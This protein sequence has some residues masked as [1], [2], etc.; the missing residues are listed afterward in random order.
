MYHPH[1]HC[2]VPGGGVSPHEE[3]RPAR[4]NFLV[5]VK[6]LSPIFRAM[7]RDAVAKELPDLKVPPGVWTKPW[8]VYSKPAPARGPK[9]LA[10][11]QAVLAYLG[12]YVH[13]VAITNRNILSI[14][15]GQVT[16]RY[17]ECGES[18][19]RTQTVAAGEF[20]RRF[21]QHTLPAGCHK[22]R[23]YGLWSA[24]KRPLLRRVQ[25]LLALDPSADPPCPCYSPWGRSCSAAKH[26]LPPL[27]DPPT[28]RPTLEGCRCPSCGQGILHR[29][30]RL[31]RHGR[32]P[33]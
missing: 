1:V 6:A 26:E 13:R 32:A 29:T 10:G 7:V 15:D 28:P 19:W 25:V 9:G 3:W 12:R 30:R 18:I 2:L 11:P 33:P 31:K 23:Y 17:Q 20:I 8:V 27:Q 21:L 16:F 22:V 5:P 24:A 14:D 4:K